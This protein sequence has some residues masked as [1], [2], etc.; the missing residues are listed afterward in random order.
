MIECK[1]IQKAVSGLLKKGG[2]IVIARESIEGGVR[3]ACSIDVFPSSASRIAHY[4][5]EDT[6][7]VEIVYY[8]KL[9]TQEHLTDTASELKSLFL[10]NL[11]EIEDRKVQT[12]NVS[13]SKDGV[14][15]VVE[16]D[17]T[18]EQA[19][20]NVDEEY[21]DMSELNMEFE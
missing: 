14:C 1:D 15:L 4:I 6:F 3:P 10:Y 20:E 21:E 8:P 19:I 11:L 5:E 17:Y 9:E 13:F 18:I 7:S 12:Y 16:C 2:F